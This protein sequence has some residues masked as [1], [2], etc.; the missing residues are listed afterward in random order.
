VV[1]LAEVGLT[2][3]EPARAEVRLLAAC[4]ARQVTCVST[5]GDMLEA[6]RRGL[7]AHGLSTRSITQGHL[8]PG[9][10]GVVAET[11]WELLRSDGS[12][13]PSATKRRP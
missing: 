12:P 6:R 13:S 4:R 7:I 5:R 1:Y 2:G 10:H 3:D 11:M 8:N 9:G